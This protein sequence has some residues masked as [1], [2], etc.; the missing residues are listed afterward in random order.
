MIPIKNG[1]GKEIF[2]VCFF[3]GLLICKDK[4][5]HNVVG[6]ETRQRRMRSAQELV[7]GGLPQETFLIV[8]VS[9]W[10]AKS[11]TNPG[12]NNSFSPVRIKQ[13]IPIKNGCGKEIFDVCF[14]HGFLICKDK[15]VT[16]LS[17]RR[18][19]NGG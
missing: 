6:Q 11:K 16:M 15:K 9:V 2:D 17:V 8:T 7:L 5:S 4:K 14:F 1:C 10:S 19:D 18:P 13:M 12:R 3:H